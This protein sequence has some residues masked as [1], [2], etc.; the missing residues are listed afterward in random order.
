MSVI[1]RKDGARFA[2]YTYRDILFSS[3]FS[4][5]RQE[6][7]EL[8]KEN[9]QY[10]RFFELGKGEI[11]VVFSNDQGYLLAE[12]VNNHF[13]NPVNMIFCEQIEDQENAILIV[14]KNGMVFLDALLPITMLIDEFVSIGTSQDIKFDIYIHGD[15]PLATK[16]SDEKFAFT[17]EL[18][19]SFNYLESPVFPQIIPDPQFE[20][21]TVYELS[22]SKSKLPKYVAGVIIIFFVF[23]LC[24]ELL[25]PAAP[26]PPP[27]PPPPQPKVVDPYTQYKSVLTTPAPSQLITDFNFQVQRFMTI[28]GWTL[29]TISLSNQQVNARLKLGG[30]SADI[31]LMWL[32]Q[33]HKVNLRVDGGSAELETQLNASNRQPPSKI[34]PIKTI[35]ANMYDR[36]RVVVDS[37]NI[38]IQS[39]QK[40]NNFVETQMSINIDSVTPSI[41]DFLA[42]EFVAMPINLDSVKFNLNDGLISGSIQFT[43]VGAPEA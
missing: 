5:F 43:V 7:S 36:I 16:P 32:K 4:A 40:R 10:V 29:T 8:Q 39:S 20:L 35:V 14:I 33:Q 38:K 42:K 34:Y 37:S 1:E 31:L 6:V 15:I 17:P 30:G 21:F 28:P 18:V 22:L 27:P 2:L 13:G 19:Q 23:F 12:C 9:G 24:Y 3:K 26:P 41:I 11:E 25:K